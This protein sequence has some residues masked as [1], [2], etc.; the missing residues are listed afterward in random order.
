MAQAEP[1]VHCSSPSL[2]PDT[3][4]PLRPHA[5]S[6]P[7]P[8][9]LSA[10][11]GL[12]DALPL[13]LA[14]FDRDGRYLYVNRRYAERFNVEP[15]AFIGRRIGDFIGPEALSRLQPHIDEVLKGTTVTFEVELDYPYAAGQVVRSTLTPVVDA[16]GC[17]TGWHGCAEN[18]TEARRND[19]R[20]RQFEFVMERTHD[21]V[22]IA[23]LAFRAQ[24]LNRAG[25]A[26]LGVDL[27][28]PFPAS[29]TVFEAIMPE[30]HGF[31]RHEFF[32]R[33][34]RDG[35]ATAELQFRN[36]V[37]G[38]PIWMEYSVVRMDD[39]QGRHTGYA[40][41]SRNL[42]EVKAAQARLAQAALQTDASLR[43]FQEL[44]DALPQIVWSSDGTGVHDYF[45]RRYYDLMG[46]EPGT[47]VDPWGSLHPDDLPR[48]A[49]AWDR[50]LTDG[51]TFEEEF[52]L[53][54]P[55]DA[56]YRWY[57]GRTV[58]VRDAG[59]VVVRWYGTSTDIH[60]QKR[61]LDDLAQSR[62]RLSAAL[63]AS[64]TGTFRWQIDTNELGWDDNL[65]RLFGLPVS[66]SIDS[67]EDFIQRVHPDDR[68]R[69]IDACVRSA[70]GG[71]DFQEE[72]R[73][74]GDS[75]RWLFDKG[76]VYRS[77]DRVYMTGA[78]TDITDRRLQEEALR[79]ADRQKDEFLGM[80]SH[81]LRTPLAPMA[82]AI[83]LLAR[84]ET[85][86]EHRRPLDVLS[87][88]VQRLRTLVDELLD[89]SRARLGK[90]Q[91]ER[92]PIDLRVIV[93]QAVDEARPLFEARRHT[94]DV[95]LPAHPAPVLVDR[96]RIGQVVD[97]LLANA[98]KYTPDR[99]VITVVV[100]EHGDDVRLRVRDSGV[101][102]EPGRLAGIFELFAQEDSA[103]D[104]SEGG[105]GIGLALVERLVQLHGGRVAASSEGPGTGAEFIVSL[106]ATRASSVVTA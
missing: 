87:R 66:A 88:Q 58:P 3:A 69:V 89:I 39:E 99:G 55:R 1:N 15:C 53:R 18:V 93:S 68:E 21:F 82:F 75:P 51:T 4:A 27:S 72:F 77:G 60:E 71:V 17:V 92:E 70:Q 41:I 97:N 13:W 102:I 83:A 52:R 46:V 44:A 26:I 94:L 9:A 84:G 28:Q 5:S 86:A 65:K 106:P 31:L 30:H 105:L 74:V 8:P 63:D 23:D 80:L 29:L 73:I 96:T 85:A 100:E 90:I 61:A 78:C 79:T 7:P 56:E 98:A 11:E 16:D 101:G 34:R 43:R 104:R 12:L 38:E 81:E 25:A 36:V 49:V 54:F 59:G 22:G 37:T 64:D 20:L 95:R 24:F 35:R 62:E 57:L 33:V 32:P 67:F 76:R 10:P 2:T 50:A 103:R 19:K 14:S 45:N 48:C 40:T 6:V 47:P 91:L 42:S